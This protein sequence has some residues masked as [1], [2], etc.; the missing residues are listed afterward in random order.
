MSLLHP[1]LS[2]PI[3]TIAKI[4]KIATIATIA[5]QSTIDLFE[6]AKTKFEAND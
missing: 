6:E 5:Y 4:A 3:A 1:L 2:A